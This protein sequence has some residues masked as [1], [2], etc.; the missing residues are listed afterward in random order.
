MAASPTDL[1][2]AAAEL[3]DAFNR[4]DWVRFESHLAP[5]VVYSE[6]GT[7]LRING[8]PAYVRHCQVWKEAFPD[9]HATIRRCVAGGNTVAQDILWEGTHT[10]QMEA[11]GATFP[12]SGQRVS[13]DASMWIRFEGGNVKEMNHQVD[14]LALM[15]QIGALPGPML[16]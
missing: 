9:F 2:R 3:I 7:G 5:D 6:T 11:P 15:Q 16:D 10:G 1:L 12:P 14:V 8:A 4:L 13:V